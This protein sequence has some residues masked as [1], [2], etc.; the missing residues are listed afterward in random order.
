MNCC[1]NQTLEVRP[2]DYKS[3]C[4]IRDKPDGPAIEAILDY[5]ADEDKFMEDFMEAWWL[6]T[7][8]GVHPPEFEC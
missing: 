2:N 7:E 5:A 3:D 4:D 8:N 1:W 6:A